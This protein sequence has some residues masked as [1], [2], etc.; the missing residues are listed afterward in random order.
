M[1]IDEIKKANIAAMKARDAD[2]R[3]ALSVV[4]TR[5]QALLTSGSGKEVVDADVLHIIQKVA[6]ELDEEAEGYVKV[7]RPES[8]EAIK[9]QKEAIICFLPKMLTEEEIRTIFNTLEDKSM[10]SVMKYFK[11]N[12]AGQCDM[13][14]VSKIARGQ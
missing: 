5:Y 8:A 2:A 9:R 14:L 3:A 7:G 12:Y 4:I 10:P 13:G 6:K 1:L 11:A